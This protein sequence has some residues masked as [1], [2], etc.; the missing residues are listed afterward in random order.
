MCFHLSQV[1]IY[2]RF[3]KLSPRNKKEFSLKIYH[4]MQGKNYSKLSI[5]NLFCE[6]HLMIH[7][8]WLEYIKVQLLMKESRLIYTWII[9]IILDHT[10]TQYVK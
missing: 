9:I 10:P 5:L 4:N 1:L 3:G 7:Q 2:P 6:V 8:T